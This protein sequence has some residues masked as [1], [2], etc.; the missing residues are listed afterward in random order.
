MKRAQKAQS[1]KE[2]E[3]HAKVMLQLHSYVLQ[4]SI[5]CANK[6]CKIYSE[7]DWVL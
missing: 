7:F 6:V 4:I 1:E 5:A 2:Y 3:F